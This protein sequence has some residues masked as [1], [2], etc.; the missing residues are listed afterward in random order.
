[1][2]Y[3]KDTNGQYWFGDH[4]M[5]VSHIRGGIIDRENPRWHGGANPYEPEL[6]RE[7]YAGPVGTIVAIV[8][9]DQIRYGFSK[10]NYVAG[11]RYMRTTAVKVALGRAL[12]DNIEPPF[13]ERREEIKEAL[14]HMHQR[15]Q[16]YFKYLAT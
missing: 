1:M 2:N 16:N 8:L 15:A 3:S 4:R 12:M 9:G 7:W 14:E 5:L 6:I 11:D 13:E 10:A